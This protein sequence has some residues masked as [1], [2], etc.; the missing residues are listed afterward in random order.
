[1]EFTTE[2]TEGTESDGMAQ[3][4]FCGKTRWAG[5]ASPAPT[6]RLIVWGFFLNAVDSF[7]AYVGVD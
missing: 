7:E 2:D 3:R 1:M 6:R 4:R 5:G